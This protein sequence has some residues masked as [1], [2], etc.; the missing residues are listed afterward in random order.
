MTKAVT[1]VEILKK[2]LKVLYMCVCVCM[3]M[4]MHVYACACMCVCTWGVMNALFFRT[5]YT[6][7]NMAIDIER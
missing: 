5:Q 6:Q 7:R 3:C 2:K 1:V 4:C